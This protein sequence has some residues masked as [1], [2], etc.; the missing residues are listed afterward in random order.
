[1]NLILSLILVYYIGINGVIIGTIAS[2][3]IIILLIKPILVFKVCFNENWKSYLKILIEYLIL[4][5]L[6]IYISENLII[7]FIDMKELKTWIDWIE[8]S[9]KL[10]LITTSV[11]FI[12]FSLNKEFRKNLKLVMK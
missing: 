4:G 11:S 2:N 5:V 3:I 7:K 6:A 1:I 10:L 8:K 12:I 9:I